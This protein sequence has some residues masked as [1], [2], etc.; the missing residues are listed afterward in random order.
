MALFPLYK[1]L[2]LNFDWFASLDEVIENSREFRI[3]NL[4]NCRAVELRTTE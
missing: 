2:V 1:S 3:Q 4:Y